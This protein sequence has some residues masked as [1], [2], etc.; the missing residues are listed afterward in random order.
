MI[1]SLDY[2]RLSAGIIPHTSYLIPDPSMTSSLFNETRNR[3]NQADGRSNRGR[4]HG[5]SAVRKDERRGV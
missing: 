2:Y 4:G 5:I 3:G 1:P